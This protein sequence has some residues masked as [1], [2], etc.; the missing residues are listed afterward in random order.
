MRCLMKWISSG[1]ILSVGRAYLPAESRLCDVTGRYARPATLIVLLSLLV[2]MPGVAQAPGAPGARGEMAE[3]IDFRPLWEAGQTTRY[4]FFTRLERSIDARMGDRGQVQTT[5]QDV[6]GEVTWTVNRVNP[7][8]S[9]S[10]TMILDWMTIEASASAG[11]ESSTTQAD[12]RRP[13]TGDAKPMYDLLAAMAGVPLTVEL[14]PDGHV[15]R[16]TGTA[17]IRART[18]NPDFVPSDLDFEETASDLAAL[19][20]APTRPVAAGVTWE[21]AFRWD[22]ELGKMNQAWTWTFDRVEPMAGVDVAVVKG[23]A[24]LKLDVQ[25]P[26][27]LPPGAPPVS[28][29]LLDA[30]AQ[31]AV[32]FDPSRHEAVARHMVTTERI[33]ASVPFPDGRTF[34]RTMTETATSQLLRIAEE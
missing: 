15:T 9:T 14:A 20:F 13:T 23:R 2:A 18:D 11:G 10:N 6:T 8:G 4:E 21:A 32:Y 19:P 3:A 22:H 25:P 27:D 1:E 12:S 26:D 17:A 5:R 7:D 31:S 28:V 33:R 24:R 29:K 30:S 16:L 34:T